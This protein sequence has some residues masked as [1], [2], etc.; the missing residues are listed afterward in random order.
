MLIQKAV[1]TAPKNAPQEVILDLE[2]ATRKTNACCWYGIAWSVSEERIAEERELKTAL[3]FLL[4]CVRA[5]ESGV[6]SVC[7]S[8]LQ[9]DA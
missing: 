9:G 3:L 1:L 2:I 8:V 7:G 4:D 5:L 6:A